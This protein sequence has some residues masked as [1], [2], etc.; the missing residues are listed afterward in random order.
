MMTTYI[1][2]H[3]GKLAAIALI[4]I[5]GASQASPITNVT[6]HQRIDSTIYDDFRGT[7]YTFYN[8]TS[9]SSNFDD[10][11]SSSTQ[12]PFGFDSAS[13]T[14]HNVISNLIND[15]N[16]LKFDALYS[17]SFSTYSAPY[18]LSVPHSYAEVRQY[19]WFDL[20]SAATLTVSHNATFTHGYGQPYWEDPSSRFAVLLDGIP[21]NAQWTLAF[22]STATDIFSLSAGIHLFEI[23]FYGH[24]RGTSSISFSDSVSFDLNSAA[25][26]VPEPSSAALL[27]LGVLGVAG[28]ARQRKLSAVR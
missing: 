16:R 18:G 5:S 27:A 19:V 6:N 13:L 1:R 7:W 11:E 26:P 20:S 22:E 4:A 21:M 15:G 28:R 24:S 2:T 9:M 8:S 14:V 10:L 17:G 25:A 3:L 23:Y 12:N